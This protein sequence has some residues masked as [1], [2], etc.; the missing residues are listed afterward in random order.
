MI[1]PT[2]QVLIKHLRSEFLGHLSSLSRVGALDA[3]L[4]C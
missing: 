1:C 4:L 2:G 3:M